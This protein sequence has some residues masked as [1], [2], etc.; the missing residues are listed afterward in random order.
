MS[1]RTC[2]EVTWTRRKTWFIT[3]PCGWHVELPG[4]CEAEDIRTMAWQHKT[5]CCRSSRLSVE[6]A[7]GYR[8]IDKRK[9]TAA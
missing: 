9:D 7:T 8:E 6:T 1:P 2:I 3:A 4:E 5:K